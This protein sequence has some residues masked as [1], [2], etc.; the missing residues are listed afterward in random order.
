MS[1]AK[2]MV[3]RC[4]VYTRKSSEEGLE[5]DFNSLHAQREACEAFIK[6]QKSEGWRLIESGYDDGGLSGGSMDRPALQRLLAD[7]ANR[8]VDTVVV[9]KVDRL[10]RS[11]ADFAKM[12]ELFDRHEVSF[13]AV[14]Q[15]FNT[16]TS[17]GRLTLNILLSFAQFE[18]EVTGER[19]RDK[20]AASK[21]RGMWMG[22][23]LPLGYDA[24]DRNLVINAK[25]AK[26]VR[27]IYEL[28]R[29]LGSVRRLK[30]ELDRRGIRSKARVSGD[31]NRSGGQPFSRGALYTLLANPVYVAEIRHKSLKYPGLHEPILDRALWDSVQHQLRTQAPERQAGQGR[32]QS[33]F[34]KGKLFDETGGRLTPSH[35]VKGGR[36]YRYYV[37]QCLLAGIASDAP[38][39]WR[40]P[41]PEIERI[42][43]EEVA[44]ALGDRSAIAGVLTEAGV[45]ATHLPA[46][47]EAGR[48]LL[49]RLKSDAQPDEILASVLHRVELR[50]TSVRLTLCLS[51]LQSKK[52]DSSHPT[53]APSLSRELPIRLRRRGVEMRLVIESQ[54]AS[55]SRQDPVLLKA[56]ARAYR[57]FQALSTNQ[58]KSIAELA[59]GEGVNE[60]Y[61]RSLIHL[62]FLA[63]E[64]VEA[65]AQGKQ[66]A[67]LTTKA[68]LTRIDL[69]PDWRDQMHALGI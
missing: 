18:R 62:A 7:I 30:E 60:R 55:H 22:G 35:S 13:V 50:E 10:T 20:I 40:L 43:A 39:G 57:W 58:V 36:R 2:P 3:R 59:A 67:E 6:S 28:Y 48:A 33:S 63:P 64:A 65:I 42:V 37:S 8:L 41:A 29:E 23:N 52:A 47:L 54:G 27:F 66:P 46:A 14:T 26:A 5:Q 4:A 16:T 9:Y 44:R 32:A 15:Q 61:I 34:L 45:S 12:V 51:P 56:V 1:P 38:K 68:L 31:G 11:L 69:P 25:E 53:P 19:I 49:E 17:M 24:Q 21:R